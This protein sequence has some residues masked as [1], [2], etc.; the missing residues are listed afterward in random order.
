MSYSNREQLQVLEDTD[1]AFVFVSGYFLELI[2][3]F[4]N[5]LVNK[6]IWKTWSLPIQ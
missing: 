3:P 4:E 2:R 1:L 5:F 6:S